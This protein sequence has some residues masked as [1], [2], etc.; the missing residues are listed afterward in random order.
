MY[1]SELV[2]YTNRNKMEET[3]GRV[4]A[5]L[6]QMKSILCKTIKSN[7]RL[8]NNW[9]HRRI[10]FSSTN[11]PVNLHCILETPQFCGGM[12]PIEMDRM[13]R[14]EVIIQLPMRI[15]INFLNRQLHLYSA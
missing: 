1:E 4:F 6:H 7:Y 9:N 10:I 5:R 11:C 13:V 12:T 15:L 8:R 14:R 2:E 3:S